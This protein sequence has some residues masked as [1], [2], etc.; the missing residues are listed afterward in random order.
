MSGYIQDKNDNKFKVIYCCNKTTPLEVK[1][2]N[3]NG[4]KAK[5]T[6]FGGDIN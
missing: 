5:L 4:Y 2:I 3:K 1:A 6:S